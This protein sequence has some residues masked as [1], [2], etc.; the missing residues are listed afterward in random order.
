MNA[1]FGPWNNKKYRSLIIEPMLIL[2]LEGQSYRGQKR[3]RLRHPRRSCRRAQGGGGQDARSE[4]GP[5]VQHPIRLSGADKKWYAFQAA[6]LHSHKFKLVLYFVPFCDWFPC[7]SYDFTIHTPA[8]YH[9]KTKKNNAKKKKEAYRRGTWELDPL[10]TWCVRT[11]KYVF[12]CIN[13]PSIHTHH[14]RCWLYACRK[15][16]SVFRDLSFNYPFF[17]CTIDKTFLFCGFSSYFLVATAE[18]V[19][20]VHFVSYLPLVRDLHIQQ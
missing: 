20:R 2:I 6:S 4:Q 19:E 9:R 10:P 7:W 5:S 13:A 18:W 14:A 8:V 12:F 11:Q 15:W 1:F 17:F 16:N 3:S